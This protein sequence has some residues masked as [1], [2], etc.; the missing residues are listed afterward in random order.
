MPSWWPSPFNFQS[1]KT[2][3][4]LPAFKP[5]GLF[6]N[7]QLAETSS[8]RKWA[9]RFWRNIRSLWNC[10]RTKEQAQGWQDKFAISLAITRENSFFFLVH[11]SKVTCGLVFYAVK[12]YFR[13]TWYALIPVANRL[14]VRIWLQVCISFVSSE[15]SGKWPSAKGV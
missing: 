2:F 15:A 14:F 6:H 12:C 7:C 1:W 8:I 4:N 9:V 13:I 3:S 11:D 5:I 10:A